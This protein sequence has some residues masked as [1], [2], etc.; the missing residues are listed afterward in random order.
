MFIFS[1]MLSLIWNQGERKKSGFLKHR[2]V[3]ITVGTEMYN[4]K[5]AWGFTSGPEFKDYVPEALLCFIASAVRT[6]N[7]HSLSYRR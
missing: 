4:D 3:V 7:M 1:I 5:K 2:A 6:F